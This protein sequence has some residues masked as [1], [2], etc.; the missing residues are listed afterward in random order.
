M[1]GTEQR[2]EDGWWGPDYDG[3]GQIQVVA[4]DRAPMGDMQR[5][6]YWERSELADKINLAAAQ[7][8]SDFLNGTN[9]VLPAYDGAVG[10]RTLI[11][12]DYSTSLFIPPFRMF[13]YPTVSKSPSYIPYADQI[14]VTVHWK[15]IDELKAALLLGRGQG[16]TSRVLTGYGLQY[17]GQPYLELTY[18]VPNFSLPPVVTLPAWRTISYFHD[19][20]F[21]EVAP[22]TKALLDGT[23]SKNKKTV[24]M[25]PIR[26]E[27]MPSLVFVWVSDTALADSG[28]NG[29]LVKGFNLREYFGKISSFSCTLNERRRILSDSLFKLFRTYC[30]NSRMSFKVWS[31]LRQM[32]VFRTDVLC[33][34]A[35]QSVFAPTT[36]TFKLDVKRQIQNRSRGRSKCTQRIHVLFWYGNEAISMSSQSSSVT[37]LLLNPS[38]V[39]EV[40]DG[41]GSSAI[42]EIMARNQ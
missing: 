3:S 14:E 15:A 41:A 25:A 19:V 34:D 8:R 39:R 32:I 11:E 37:S 29:G 40:R 36:I 28:E 24:T 10:T 1:T 4:S 18:V 23:G 6:G 42:T 20:A 2:E 5:L 21:D 31:E 22:L 35:Q 26:I 17:A 38:D 33:T 7:R 16:Q 30:P 13:D 27:S 9:I 12:Y